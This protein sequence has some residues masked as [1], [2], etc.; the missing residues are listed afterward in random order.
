MNTLI[1]RDLILQ[2]GNHPSPTLLRHEFRAMGVG[3]MAALETGGPLA[4]L[5]LEQVP[6]WFEEWE[7]AL[8]RFRPDSELSLLNRRTGSRVPVS[9]IVWEVLQVSLSA[10]EETGGL[11][12]PTVLSAI[13]SAGYDR[14]FDAL[15]KDN[16]SGA[17]DTP[18][19]HL[20]EEPVPDWRQVEI[21]PAERAVRLPA[22]V[23]L[24]FGGT[25]KGWCADR[26]ISLL[27]PAGPALVD[28]GGDIAVSGPMLDGSP[29]PIGIADP[30]RPDSDMTLLRIFNGGIATSGRDYRRW[31]HKGREMHH[32]I[33]PR[34]RQPAETD[35][36]A[37]TIVGPSALAAEV[38]AKAVLI[39]G[40][41]RGTEWLQARPELA[42]LM[43][44]ENGK[45]LQTPNFAE[46][47]W[48]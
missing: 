3:M 30:F 27:G 12:T 44:L 28:A 29:W 38:A 43:V 4:H 47:I 8:S 34:T 14:T 42:G 25:A 21:D 1:T 39:L 31:Q 37:V 40:S 36:L 35:L 24:D 32:I 9:S 5:S 20:S 45:T 48:S 22:G 2:A 23:G 18:G 16:R 15:P 19:T 11:V 7:Q 6:R 17:P 10:A 13:E 46:L 33:D 41:Q 26:A